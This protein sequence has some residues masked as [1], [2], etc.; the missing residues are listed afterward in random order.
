MVKDSSTNSMAL[1]APVLV[2]L[3]RIKDQ[4]SPKGM[5]SYPEHGRS[6]FL[7]NA[8]N[9]VN[10]LTQDRRPKTE[11]LGVC[12]PSIH[13]SMA[14]QLFVGPW[15]LFSFLIFYTV[16]RIPWTGDQP[17][18][19]PLSAYTG[20]HEHKINAHRHQCLEWDMNPRSQCTRGRR[21][22]MP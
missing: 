18:A 19:R 11:S 22:F 17:V 20:Q 15:R 14:L 10:T 12:H 7:R 5:H 3:S 13:L 4:F 2:H 1:R 8:G 9:T 21:R 6:T 16:G